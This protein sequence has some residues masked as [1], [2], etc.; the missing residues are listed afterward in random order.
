MRK[1]KPTQKTV[2]DISKLD[3]TPPKSSLVSESCFDNKTRDGI[4]NQHFTADVIEAWRERSIELIRFNLDTNPDA[5]RV[6][7]GDEDVLFVAASYSDGWLRDILDAV[8]EHGADMFD[9]EPFD[10]IITSEPY[11]Y[12][13]S[14]MEDSGV[15]N[16]T[17]ASDHLINELS[18]SFEAALTR[19]FREYQ[20]TT[21]HGKFPI[22]H[23][24]PVDHE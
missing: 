15:E 18:Y 24:C 22:T 23:F 17:E 7:K 4:D 12:G 6:V 21:Y 20:V 14:L 10:E 5:L 11:L 16:S 2:S 13:D 19:P 1:R 8:E 3:V 9:V